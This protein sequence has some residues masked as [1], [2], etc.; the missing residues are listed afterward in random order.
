MRAPFRAASQR[1]PP[2]PRL[3]AQAPGNPMPKPRKGE[4]QGKLPAKGKK[5]KKKKAKEKRR[6]EKQDK[7]VAPPEEDELTTPEQT[8]NEM[9]AAETPAVDV[10]NLFGEAARMQFR[11]VVKPA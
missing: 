3:S 5:K 9:R 6:K 11:R 4:D 8:E 1:D 2:Y 10:S 7:T